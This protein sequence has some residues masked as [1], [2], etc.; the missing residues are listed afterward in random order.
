VGVQRIEP[1]LDIAMTDRKRRIS[2]A[3]LTVVD[4]TPL[5]L[6]DAA[7]A[8]GF[9]S[10][11]LRIVA[12][13]P[14]DRIVPVVG[15]EA[16]IRSIENRLAETGIDILDVEAIWLTADSDVSSYA[17]VFET[18][19]RLGAAHVLVVGNDPDE[20]RVIENFARLAAL[21]RPFGLKAM[22]E[23]IPYCQTRTVE[24]A[25]RVVS[26]AAQPNAGVLVDALHLSRSGGS[27]ADLRVLDP[28][29][30]SYGQIC[31]ARKSPPVTRDRL[32]MEARTD[33]FYPGRGGL[34]LTELLDA[35]PAGIPL[36]VEA[37][38]VEYSH[39]APVE[40]G[41]LCGEMTRAFLDAYQH[42]GSPTR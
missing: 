33:R 3:H 24:A 8:G 37:P 16:M 26:Q 38:C 9:D 36:G 11:G 4:A 34:P 23:F 29:W 31:D 41:R 25:H 14:T 22:L 20:G 27:P 2:L 13:M 12:P 6:I 35:L 30:L 10:I 5:E 18:G 28:T 39:L 19:A 32:R 17:Q 21:A 7:K 1:V 40:R 42:R 15:D